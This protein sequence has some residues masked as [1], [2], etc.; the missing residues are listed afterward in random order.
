MI[1]LEEVYD[2]LCVSIGAGCG[3]PSR[4]CEMPGFISKTLYASR[5]CY[6]IK[7]LTCP[8]VKVYHVKALFDQVYGG[9]EGLSL[10]TVD[11]Q[12]VRMSTESS[13]I[14]AGMDWT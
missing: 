1:G 10:D 12:V 13:A 7:V 2:S 8:G 5:G 14:V 6:I 4:A 11:V 3:D 9:E